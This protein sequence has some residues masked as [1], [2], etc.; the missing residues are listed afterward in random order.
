TGSSSSTL[1]RQAKTLLDA[2]IAELGLSVSAEQADALIN[3]L[4]LMLKWNRRV[5][6]TAITD[7]EEMVR[8]HLLDSLSLSPYII[9]QRIVDVGSGAG[10][11]GIPLA[12]NHPAATFV[13]LDSN[14][15]KTRFLLQAKIQLHLGNVI[16][17]NC[18]VEHYAS[19][20]RIDIVLCRAF[21]SLGEIVNK[22]GHLMASGCTLLAMKG[23]HPAQEL[24]KLPAGFSVLGVDRLRIP[25]LD[26]ER[27]L[28]KITKTS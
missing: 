22:S 1:P 18:R 8:R 23:Q 15:K 25:G 28:V 6:L 21:S 12:L 5:N 9:G 26:S 7:L 11:P 24:E 13:L 3:Y 17:E 10:L 19:P 4:Q 27:H 20:E 14:S 2:G 16:I